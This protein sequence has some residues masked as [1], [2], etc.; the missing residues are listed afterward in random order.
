M[1]YNL[2]K[3]LLSKTWETEDFKDVGKKWNSFHYGN[4][5]Y[6]P[7]QNSLE[8]SQNIRNRSTIGARNLSPRI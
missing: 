2:C 6:S 8:F 5:A 7:L 4:N 1:S 3:W